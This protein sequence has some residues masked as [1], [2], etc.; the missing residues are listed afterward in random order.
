MVSWCVRLTVLVGLGMIG[1]AAPETTARPAKEASPMD[2]P[3]ALIAQA[4]KAYTEVQ[5][6]SCTL[7]KRERLDGQAKPTES[8][9]QMAVRARPFS[10]HLRWRE[11]RELVGQEACYVEGRHNGRMRVRA[12]GALGALGFIT[13]EPNDPRARRNSRH[14]ITE[15]GIGNLI[16]SYA[17]HWE[18]ERQ[19]N[20]T[21]VHLATYEYNRRRCVRVE[22]VHPNNNGRFAFYRSVVYFDKETYLPVRVECY[23]WPRYDGDKGEVVE[24]YSYAN[25]RINIGLDDAHFNK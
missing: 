14:A 21:V 25:L 2:E 10:V 22:T 6:Y 12:A 24:V 8:V 1:A 13:L 23:D 4:R 5:D 7:I 18:E 15:A 19:L 3:L 9:I 11:P 17:G 16:E 20:Q